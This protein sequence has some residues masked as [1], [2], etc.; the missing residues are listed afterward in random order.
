M[1]V[2]ELEELF[3]A[4]ETLTC[5]KPVE[6]NELLIVTNGG[7]AGVLAVD[8]LMRS[9]GRLAPLAETRRRQARHGASRQLVARQSGR[10]HRRRVTRAL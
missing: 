4:A 6:G 2:D 3:A 7:G 10:H 8:D 9:G 5:L 1:R